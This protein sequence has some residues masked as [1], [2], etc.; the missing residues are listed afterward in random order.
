MVSVAGSLEV[1]M[2][3]KVSTSEE[4]DRSEASDVTILPVMLPAVTA[5][6]PG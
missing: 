1:V 5:P 6:T 4:L 3:A 2:A